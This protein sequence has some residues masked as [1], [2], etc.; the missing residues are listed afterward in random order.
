V[1]GSGGMPRQSNFNNLPLQTS[2]SVR[3]EPKGTFGAV[4][5]RMVTAPK[6]WGHT[7][8]IITDSADIKHIPQNRPCE[9]MATQTL[10]VRSLE[11]YDAIN[12][13]Y[14]S[15]QLDETVRLLWK[16]YVAGSIGEGEATYLASIIDSRHPLGRH[17]APGHA[18]PL[19][20]VAGRIGSRFT[21]R[22]RPR[23]PDRRAS[24]DRRRM[25]GGSS[26]LPVNLRLPYSEGQRS[27]LCIVAGEV[28]RQGIC[29]FPIDKIAALAGVC[30]TTVQTTMHEAR[31]LGHIKITERPRPGRKSLPNIV[32]I[33]SPEWLAWI[34][35]KP[36]AARLIGSNFSK[37]VSTTKNTE[38]SKKVAFNENEQGRGDESFRRTSTFAAKPMLA[39][40]ERGP[41]GHRRT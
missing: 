23:S 1:V 38:V 20:K 3:I 19:G 2:A 13:C 28:K 4:T 21:P 37:M 34:R 10:G 9:A 31:R 18:T 41:C 5:N 17:T 30:R 22:Q 40:A 32:E 8:Q 29:D 15:D 11:I 12:K 14:D 25:L 39:S 26:A 7:E 33:I 27:V 36:P 6:S 35:R 16:G 24:R